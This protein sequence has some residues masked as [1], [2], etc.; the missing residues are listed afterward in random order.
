[1]KGQSIRGKVREVPFW[2]FGLFVFFN[3][4]PRALSWWLRRATPLLSLPSPV[5]LQQVA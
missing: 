5:L 2:F 1:M 4:S 3:N